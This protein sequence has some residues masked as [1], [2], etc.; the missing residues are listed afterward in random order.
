MQWSSLHYVTKLRL[1]SANLRQRQNLNR[2]LD[3]GPDVTDVC[4]SIV[5]SITLSASVISPSVVK[6]GRWLYNKC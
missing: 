3:S 4:Q 2:N 1:E 5:K 6:I